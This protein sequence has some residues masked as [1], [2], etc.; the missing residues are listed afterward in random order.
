MTVVDYNIHTVKY[1]PVLL[2]K[3]TC[4]TFTPQIKGVLQM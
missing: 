3:N 1:Q 4:N 2:H